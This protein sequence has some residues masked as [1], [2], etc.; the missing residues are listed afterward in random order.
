MHDGV[1]H[2][3]GAHH[4]HEHVHEAAHSHLHA[5]TGEHSHVHEGLDL[6]IVHAHEHTHTVVHDHDHAHEGDHTHMHSTAAGGDRAET[7]ALLAYTLQHNQHHKIELLELQQELQQL[8]QNA[9]AEEL[10]L[11]ISDYAA[12]NARLSAILESI[13]E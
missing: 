2:S 12:G 10:G 5:H 3:G 13:K 11:A 6:S 7:I 1:D 4:T 8:G 9:A